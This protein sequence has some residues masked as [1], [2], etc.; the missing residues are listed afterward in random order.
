VI[1]GW[2]A[3]AV[4]HADPALAED[5]ARPLDDDLAPVPAPEGS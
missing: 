2:R 4:V 1:V 3:T 5:R